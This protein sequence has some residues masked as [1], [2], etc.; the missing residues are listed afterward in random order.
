MLVGLFKTPIYSI[1]EEK[2]KQSKKPNVEQKDHKNLPFP[3]SL[4]F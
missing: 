2:L 4:A 3:I 1:Q